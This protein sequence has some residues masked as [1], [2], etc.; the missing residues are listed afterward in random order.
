MI[1]FSCLY[2]HVDLFIDFVQRCASVCERTNDQTFAGDI[3]ETFLSVRACS[4]VCDH[5]RAC[6]TMCDRVLACSTMCDRVQPFSAARM[7][8]RGANLIYICA[9]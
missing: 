7:A 3:F 6:L 2:L 9:S 8:Y 1:L 4:N 5:V